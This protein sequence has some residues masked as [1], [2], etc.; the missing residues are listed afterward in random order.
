MMKNLLQLMCIYVSGILY[1]VLSITGCS[2]NPYTGSMLTAS[3][4][5]DYLRYP[6]AGTICL[7]SGTDASCLKLIPKTT[8][9][10]ENVNRPVIHIYPRKLIYIFY[11]KGDPFLTAERAVDTREIV[12]ELQHPIQPLP[13][14]SGDN[15]NTTSEPHSGV[16]GIYYVEPTNPP[17]SEPQP[18]SQPTVNRNPSPPSGPVNDPQPQPQLPVVGQTPV[19]NNPQPQP[20]PQW[21]IT[22]YAPKGT[23]LNSKLPYSKTGF[24]ITINDEAIHE[25]NIENFIYVVKDDAKPE[26][27][28]QYGIR[29]WYRTD[30]KQLT[31]TVSRDDITGTSEQVEPITVLTVEF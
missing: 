26:N 16:L 28:K 22:V 24:E 5:D 19:N 21:L 3:D 17:T 8:G 27:E 11:H 10:Q 23:P 13:D 29:F 6:D 31:V 15:E 4:V 1:I 18:Q 30:A 7:A 2:E 12:K 9:G 25:G 20:Q 14:V